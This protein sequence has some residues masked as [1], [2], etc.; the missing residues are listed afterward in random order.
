M[1]VTYTWKRRRIAFWIG[2]IERIP[3][4]QEEPYV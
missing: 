1:A 2:S 4:L 3:A